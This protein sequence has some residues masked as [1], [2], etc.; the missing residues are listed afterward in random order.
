MSSWIHN[1]EF[2]QRSKLDVH[3]CDSSLCRWHSEP[4]DWMRTNTKGVIND[5]KENN[6]RDWAQEHTDIWSQDLA[7]VTQKKQLVRLTKWYETRRRSPQGEGISWV[8]CSSVFMVTNDLP[9]DSALWRLL[10]AK[11]D[12]S[13]R[14]RVPAQSCIVDSGSSLETDGTW[15]YKPKL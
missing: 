2:K 4:W 8:K 14:S 12:I 9:L 7:K 15:N 1:L 3:I 6:S 11:K 5:R 10:E 13:T